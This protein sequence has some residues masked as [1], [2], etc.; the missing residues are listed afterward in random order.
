MIL[1][2][3]FAKLSEQAKQATAKK[4]LYALEL[5][6]KAENELKSAVAPRISFEVICFKVAGGSGETDPEML[7]LRVREL[8]RR[9]VAAQQV[10]KPEAP[11][12]D[13]GKGKKIWAAALSAVRAQGADI[14]L[15]ACENISAVYILENEFVV[16]ADEVQ[17]SLLSQKENHSLLSG[18]VKEN[19]LML[20]VINTEKQKIKEADIVQDLKKLIGGDLKIEK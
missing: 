9:G 6:N 2:S 13:Y 10:K 14:L 17:Y 12:K 18:I 15:K 19:G 20:T 11:Q 8:E 1:G 7:E 3:V 4:L 16:E 5:F